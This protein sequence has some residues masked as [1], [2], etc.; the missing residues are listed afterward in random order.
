MTLEHLERRQSWCPWLPREQDTRA[1]RALGVGRLDP[2]NVDAVR[3]IDQQYR[4]E[5]AL[6]ERVRLISSTGEASPP[7]LSQ[8][9]AQGAAYPE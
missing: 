7:Q 2:V 5:A 1:V 9:K 3:A 6:A 8:P 4:P